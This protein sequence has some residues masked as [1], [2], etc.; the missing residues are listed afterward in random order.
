MEKPKKLSEQINQVDGLYREA[1]KGEK[2]K[3]ILEILDPILEARL[4]VLLD[5]FRQA[6]PEIGAMLDFRAQICEVW[7]MRQQLS[8]AVKVGKSAEQTLEGLVQAA[9]ERGSLDNP[10]SGNRTDHH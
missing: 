2:A 6:P 4:G 3:A 9:L 5:G 1:A 8:V 7:R 10:S